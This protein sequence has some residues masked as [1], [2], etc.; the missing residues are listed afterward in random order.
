MNQNVTSLLSLIETTYQSEINSIIEEKLKSILEE[1]DKPIYQ[2][3]ITIDRIINYRTNKTIVICVIL[4]KD[5]KHYQSYELKLN[6]EIL[7]YQDDLHRQSGVT[8]HNPFNN[9]HIN[10]INN[11]NA[12][13]DISLHQAHITLG[14]LNIIYDLFKQEV[15]NVKPDIISPDESLRILKNIIITDANSK[16][17]YEDQEHDFISKKEIPEEPASEE[18]V[19]YKLN[20]RHSH[21]HQYGVGKAIVDLGEVTIIYDTINRRI[22]KIIPDVVSEESCLAEMINKS[23]I[24]IRHRQEHDEDKKN[25]QEYQ[26]RRV[27]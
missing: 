12:H 17:I 10:L 4:K 23:I 22:D 13:V 9:I 25:N 1:N 14:K 16:I 7:S 2:D 15:V 18:E 11:D 8:L 20:Y 26:R 3:N 24:K 19:R 21:V 27:R 5:N 6:G